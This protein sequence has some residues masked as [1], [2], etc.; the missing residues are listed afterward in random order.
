MN[1]SWKSRVRQSVLGTAGFAVARRL[2]A[3]VPRIIMYHGFGSDGDPH[4]GGLKASAFKKQVEHI[5]RYYSPMTL[6]DLVS[7]KAA[8]GGY[9]RRAVVITVD[10]GYSNFH[11]FAWPILR[12]YRVP[13]TVF[14]VTELL[15]NGGWIWTDKLRYV[16]RA[17]QST[18]TAPAQD[19]KSINK[20]MKKMPIPERD[21][22]L[23]ELAE[24]NGV[25]IP[26]K[27]PTEFALMGWDQ[28]RELQHSGLIEMG[29]HTRRHP[30]L[31]RVGSDDSWSELN[32]SKG[33]L[34]RNL[35]TEIHSFCYPNGLEGDYRPDQVDMLRRAGYLCAAASHLGYVSKNS[36]WY[37]LPRIGAPAGEMNLWF[38]YLDGAEYLQ[39]MLLRDIKRGTASL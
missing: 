31:A 28:L 39:R 35:G 19:P 32:G 21:A 34:E 4:S 25:R 22:Y 9:P 20:L 13:A 18:S 29:S 17:G 30:I 3:K 12:E 1:A 2:T 15:E 5:V 23:A 33:D 36:D 27:A 8:T 26:E 14:V 37:A 6:R 38:K 11:D 24:R 7:H 16:L 10:D